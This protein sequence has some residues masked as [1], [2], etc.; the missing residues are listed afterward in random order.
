MTTFGSGVGWLVRPHASCLRGQRCIIPLAAWASVNAD[1]VFAVNWNPGGSIYQTNASFSNLQVYDEA[2][3]GAQVASRARHM[4]R[5]R[6][7]AP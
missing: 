7:A 5:T 1:G 6:S 4:P 2:L 3:T